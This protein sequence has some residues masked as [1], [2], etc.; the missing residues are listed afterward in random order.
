MFQGNFQGGE[1]ASRPPVRRR[2]LGRAAFCAVLALSLCCGLFS[3]CGGNR[4]ASSETPSSRAVSSGATVSKIA[5]VSSRPSSSR[6]P[7]ASVVYENKEYG[8]RVALPED[9]KGYQ[10]L[11]QQWAAFKVSDPGAGN[12]VFG[13]EIVLRSPKWTQAKP[14]QDIPIMI[15]SPEHWQQLNQDVIHIG[16]AP[17]GPRELARNARYVFALPARYNFAFPEGYEEVEKIID[18]GAVTAFEWTL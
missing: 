15:F 11:T 7:A 16:A 10:V 9:W 12:T 2:R 8:L 5:A 14:Y 13:P 1:R 6:A 4:A 3:A 18:S 17:I